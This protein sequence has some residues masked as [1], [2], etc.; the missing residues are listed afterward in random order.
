MTLASDGEALALLRREFPELPFLELPSYEVVYSK[1]G[2]WLQWS[3]LLQSPRIM[4]RVKEEYRV[5][6][7][8]LEN[9]AI[10]LIISDNRYG[11]YADGVKSVI[12][13][14]Q[15]NIQAP[16]A[17]SWVNRIHKRLLNRFLECWIPDDEAR[18]LSGDLSRGDLDIPIRF[19]GAQ[20]RFQKKDITDRISVLA[21]LSGPE[22]QRSILEEELISVLSE[23]E[24]AVL[25][26]GVMG[27]KKDEEKDGLRLIGHALS[28]EMEELLNSAD[29]VIC[30][31]GYSS[32]MDLEVLDKKAILIP[33][34]GQSEQE[35][36]GRN[37]AGREN[38]E[39]L[40]QDEIADRLA[41]LISS[42]I[43]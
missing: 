42:T 11:I 22:P 35:Y 19:I 15:L 37:L 7:E 5:L 9:E 25:V 10:D 4:N 20:S 6:G 24:G 40:A 38:Y 8:F 36:L 41:G 32:L 23:M 31:A 1:Q 14:H 17:A 33:T 3:I 26:R 43:L 18:S 13:C 30:R 28:A 12:I 2:T 27:D 21:V 39:V 34:P 16:V 29:L